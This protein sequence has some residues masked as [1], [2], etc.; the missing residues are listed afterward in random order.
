VNNLEGGN[1]GNLNTIIKLAK[2][3]SEDDLDLAHRILEWFW[4]KPNERTAAAYLEKA[5]RPGGMD[6][7]S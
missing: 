4:E 2:G 5:L 6:S 1:G 7:D 3:L